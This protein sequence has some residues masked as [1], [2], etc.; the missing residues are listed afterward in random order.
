MDK[1]IWIAICILVLFV[2]TYDPK[3]GT[4]E[5]VLPPPTRQQQR[6]S[7]LSGG[8][9]DYREF[10]SARYQGLQFAE[11]DPIRVPTGPKVMNGVLM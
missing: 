6:D 3:S 11:V 5:K 7:P 8:V 9:N 2:L 1:L 4:L 10:E